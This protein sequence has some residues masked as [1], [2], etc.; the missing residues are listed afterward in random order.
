MVANQRPADHWWSM[1]PGRLATAA[2]DDFLE[3]QSLFQLQSSDS[4]DLCLKIL[5][6]NRDKR[7][8]VELKKIRANS[9]N[10]LNSIFTMNIYCRSESNYQQKAAW[11]HLLTSPQRLWGRWK[12]PSVV[13]QGLRHWNQ[14]HW[15]NFRWPHRLRRT[16]KR[17]P[18]PSEQNSH[19]TAEKVNSNWHVY[20][21][22][23]DNISF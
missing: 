20:G 23:S 2:L 4:G 1:R 17:Q 12:G 8:N 5:F 10:P 19:F 11:A 22:E 13:G 14:I 21:S 16:M 18:F 3:F 7:W 6:W 15:Q 9:S